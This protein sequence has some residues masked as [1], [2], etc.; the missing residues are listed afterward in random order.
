MSEIKIGR[1]VLPDMGTNCYF[2]YRSGEKGVVVVDPGQD[3]VGIYEKLQRNGFTVQAILLTHGHFDHICGCSALRDLSGASVYAPLLEKEILQDAH[4][5][6][7]A[8]YVGA[9][10]LDADE[11]LQDGDTLTV[12][13]IHFDVIA[14]P[15]HTVGGAC[16]YIEEAH[17][18]L[19]GD[20][21][22]L[23]SVGRTDHPTGDPQLLIHSIRN[24][25]FVLP[26]DTKVYPGHGD[27]TTIGHEK[28]AN[29]Y[30]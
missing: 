13:D 19:S 7:S 2:L 15:G 17:F 1:I 12:C 27:S 21:L 3:G 24:K 16:F 29:P 4:K 8:R 14:L 28:K 6:L 5:N 10:T 25:L 22:F 30:C 18:L 20:S 11:Y 26:E 23:E 9:Y